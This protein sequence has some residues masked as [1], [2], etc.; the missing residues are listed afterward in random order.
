[1]LSKASQ[2]L[3][4]L[5]TF[6]PWGTLVEPEVLGQTDLWALPIGHGERPRLLNYFKFKGLSKGLSKDEQQHG[7]WPLRWFR[8]LLAL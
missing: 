1:M 7:G 2:A 4:S 3:R 5:S 8:C 6:G